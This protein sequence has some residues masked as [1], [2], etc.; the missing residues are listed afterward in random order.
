MLRAIFFL[1]M[2]F[3]ILYRS[4]GTGKEKESRCLVGSRPLTKREIRHFHV[5]VVQ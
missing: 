3:K 2:N 5:E 1:E 4:S